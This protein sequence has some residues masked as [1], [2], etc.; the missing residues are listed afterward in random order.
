[1]AASTKKSADL[2]QNLSSNTLFHFTNSFE[3]L[4]SILR[5]GFRLSYVPEVLPKKIQKDMSVCYI[6]PMI[7][8]C[9]IPLGGVKVH[10]QRYGSYGL[11]IHK[12]FCKRANINPV[13][14]IHDSRVFNNIIPEPMINSSSVIPYLKKYSGKNIKKNSIFRFYNEREW[15]HVDGSKTEMIHA[16]EERIRK[17][18]RELNKNAT[19]FLLFNPDDIE[20]II[21]ENKS[22]VIKIIDFIDKCMKASEQDKKILY[23]KVISATRVRYDF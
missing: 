1:M 14:Y 19:T 7:C 18:C 6:V 12:N 8:F 15:R 17:R 10:L 20:Y 2:S 5:N 21:V 16:D 3:K 23:T 22:E 11:G 4:K 13:F 9:D